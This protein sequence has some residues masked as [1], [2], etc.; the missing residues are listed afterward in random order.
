MI[1]WQYCRMRSC[2]HS[3]NLGGWH[4][5]AA[6][7]GRERAEWLPSVLGSPGTMLCDDA[8]SIGYGLGRF[9]SQACVMHVGLAGML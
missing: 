9:G 8:V 7:S 2:R 6:C 3:Q 4:A 1:W 5:T